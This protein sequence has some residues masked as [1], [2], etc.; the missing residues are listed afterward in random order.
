MKEKNPG[1]SSVG[2]WPN[3]PFISVEGRGCM[4]VIVNTTFIFFPCR[5]KC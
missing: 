3:C 5:V 2:T 1:L 4:N